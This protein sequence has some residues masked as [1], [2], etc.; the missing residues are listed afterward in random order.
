M[1]IT[2]KPL[3]QYNSSRRWVLKFNVHHI[4]IRLLKKKSDGCSIG[5]QMSSNLVQVLQ[6]W[7]T[8]VLF[9]ANK[10]DLDKKGTEI[11]GVT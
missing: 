10:C 2:F 7:N 9:T 4:L 8:G 6:L 3:I 11:Y 5:R 1:P